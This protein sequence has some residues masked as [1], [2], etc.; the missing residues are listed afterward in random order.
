MKTTD[1]LRENVREVGD[2]VWE[3]SPD[4][5]PGMRVPARVYASRALLEQM[6]QGVFEQVTNVACL[7]GIVGAALCMPD[8][9][10]GYGFPIGGVAA[11]REDSGVISPG[12]I[13]F[14]I[15]CGMR[16]IRT[17]LTE[18]AVRPRLAELIVALFT[19]VPSGVGAKGLVHLSEPDFERVMVEGAGWCAGRGLGFPETWITAK[20]GGSLA[21]ADPAHVSAHAMARG[22]DQLGTLGSGDHYLE[23]QVIPRDGIHDARAAR[24]FGVEA[25]F[26]TRS[27]ARTPRPR[28]TGSGRGTWPARRCTRTP[29]RSPSRSRA[30]RR[31]RIVPRR[32]NLPRCDQV[33][34][35]GASPF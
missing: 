14:D 24:A 6:D 32:L 23:I 31:S 4:A 33:G 26:A 13:G 17:G 8:G 12:G 9:H 1:K 29:S 11:F 30:A 10:W 19:A 35:R 7:P 27:R 15:N 25:Q 16:L 34:D 21:G 20:G 28:S 5:K 18:D 22:T 2:C 3:I